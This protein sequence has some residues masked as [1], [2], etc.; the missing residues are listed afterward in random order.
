MSRVGHDDL[1]ALVFASQTEVFLD[2]PHRSKLALSTRHRLKRHL[3]HSGADFQ[4]V[5][6]FIVNRKKTLEVMFRQMRV[7]VGDAWKLSDDL[8][9]PRIVFHR[10]GTKRVETGVNAEVPLG[11]PGVMSHHFGFREAGPPSGIFPQQ[12]FGNGGL[13]RC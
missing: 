11:E 3:V 7:D 1:R 13:T 9:N 10:A 2:A 12:A 4:H 8:V 5:L 6:H